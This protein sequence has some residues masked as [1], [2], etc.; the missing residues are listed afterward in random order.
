MRGRAGLS[1][2]VGGLLSGV[3]LAQP[4][5]WEVT[6]TSAS[7]S[8]LGTV[9]VNGVPAAAG[10]WIGAFDPSGHCAGAA[11]II[12]NSGTAYMSL[13]VYGDDP[14]T[15]AVDEGITGAEPFTL[16]L[17]PAGSGAVVPYPNADSPLPLTGWA[18]TN[19]AP[20]PAFADPTAVFDFAF[21]A[22]VALACPPATLCPA[23]DPWPLNPMPPGGLLAGSG[24]GPD[25]L[26]DAA[27]AGLGLHI[28]SY[29]WGATTVTCSVEVTATPD[30]TV[31]TTGPFCS[32]DAPVL[33]TAATSGG[34]W[35]GTGVFPAAGGGAVFD[36]GAVAP[37]TY[38]VTYTLD[39]P[40]C[41]A[42]AT[43]AL[44]VLPAPTPPLITATTDGTLVASVGG[45][46]A[47]NGGVTFV[48]Y[49]LDG[50][51]VAEG[52]EGPEL[53]TPLS[54]PT[55]L[56]AATNSY[57]CTA[58]SAP[59]LFGPAAVGAPAAG[60]WTLTANA[61]GTLLS[62]RPLDELRL[63]DAAGRELSPSR[64]PG[65]GCYLV[66]ARSGTTWLRQRLVVA[67][68]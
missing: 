7:G 1:A 12:L 39:L 48:W 21:D 59:F 18:N 17:A 10:S 31:L 63:F 45:G 42:T 29:T 37:G 55:Y 24:V 14:M 52:T 6:P 15:A 28:L 26:F 38:P 35:W 34:T 47:G 65:P 27:A 54:G 9:T 51:P 41:S 32:G 33:L 20:L 2:A 61:D 19:G 36:P 53:G 68:A 8:V 44:A 56:V 46:G 50:T 66:V 5:G 16:R 62:S 13:A 30:A 60:A 58:L 4:A 49:V 67:G 11:Q 64:L 25:G 23:S 40:G 43:A 22:A 57:G 3:A